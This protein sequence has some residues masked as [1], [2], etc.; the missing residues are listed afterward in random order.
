MRQPRD[1]R[2]RY[3]RELRRVVRS[4]FAP[5]LTSTQAVDDA[6][7][8]DRILVEFIVE[9]EAGAALSAEFGGAFAALLGDAAPSAGASAEE[10][11]DTLRARAAEFVASAASSHDEGVLERARAAVE[12]EHRFLERLDELRGAVSADV[13]AFDQRAP[14]QCSVTAGDLMTYLRSRVSDATNLAVTSVALVPGGRS[15]ETLQVTLTGTRELPPEV[16]V[17]KDRPVGVLQTRAADEFAI[18]KAVHDFGGVPVPKPFFADAD[19]NLPGSGTVIVMERVPGRKAGEFFPDLAAPPA[20]HREIGVQLAAALAR[21]HS[22]PLDRLTGTRLGTSP[23]AVTEAG[24]VETVD[25]IT[26]RIGELTGPANVTVPMA[27]RW[28]HDHVRDVLGAPRVAL[29]QGDFGLHNT[30]VDGARVTALVDWEAAAVGP[31]A[32]ELAA[33]WNTAT[34]LM[35]WSDFIDA[36]IDAGGRAEDADPRAI[37]YY[38]VLSALGAFMASRTGGHLFRTGAKRDLQTAHSGLDSQF[39]CARNLARALGDAM[40]ASRGR[41]Q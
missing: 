41:A 21:L 15:K 23:A 40:S 17:R 12:V 4:E 19:A 1:E 28:L 11:F 27:R 37:A 20:H 30:L 36:Y 24:V 25:G 10:R 29:L 26:A 33:A 18:I 13:D 31:P 6:G 5:E 2:A 34:A 32:R 38:R 14:N 16:I 9:E 8:V 7:L 3:Y 22:L 39:R 35:P